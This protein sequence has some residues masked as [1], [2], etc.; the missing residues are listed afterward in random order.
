MHTLPTLY[1]VLL[2]EHC[3]VCTH[4]ASVTVEK[5]PKIAEYFQ[6]GLS[7]SVQCEFLHVYVNKLSLGRQGKGKQIHYAQDS[8]AKIRAALGQGQGGIRTHDTLQSKRVLYQLSYQGN[9]AGR[10]SNLQHNTRQGKPQTTVLWHSILSLSMYVCKTV[11]CVWVSQQL[12]VAPAEALVR[13]GSGSSGSS[14][15]S[16][17]LLSLPTS[18]P[19]T[20]PTTLNTAGS[21]PSLLANISTSVLYNIYNTMG[22][23]DLPLPFRLVVFPCT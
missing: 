14:V 4:R 5:P 2:V 18:D 16:R 20:T 19:Q 17:D 7:C 13:S 23:V 3:L 12:S 6:Y 15:T 22:I 11:Y 10:G 1:D 9:S 21:V 8:S